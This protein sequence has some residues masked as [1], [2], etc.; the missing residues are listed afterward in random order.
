[1]P[2]SERATLRSAYL[3][4]VCLVTLVLVIFA[5]VNAVRNVVELAYPDPGY[6]GF[7][8]KPA[9]APGQTEEE[10]EEDEEERR[11]AA[12]DSQR[13]SALV[14]LIGNGAMLLVAAPVYLYHWRRVQAEQPP[15]TPPAVPS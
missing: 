2:G 10:A 1:M 5:T 8:S 3:Y 4:L 14:G 12:E 6:Y 11:Q 15:R 7:E 13:R 9:L